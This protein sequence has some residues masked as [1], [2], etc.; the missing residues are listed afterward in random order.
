VLDSGAIDP[1]SLALA[2]L[3]LTWANAG[4][5]RSAALTRF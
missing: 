4:T 5:A 1:G 3:H 2:G